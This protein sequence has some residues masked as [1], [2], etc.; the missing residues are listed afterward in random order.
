MYVKKKTETCKTCRT[1]AKLAGFARNLREICANLRNCFCKTYANLRKNYGPVC[2]GTVCSCLML[3]GAAPA[4]P[5]ERPHRRAR[6][7]VVAVLRRSSARRERT[8][9]RAPSSR[10]GASSRSARRTSAWAS[11][12]PRSRAAGALRFI[13]MLRQEQTVP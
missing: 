8:S 5:M 2:Y 10:S 3:A 13:R 11:T 7:V 9:R 6:H 4:G 1:C 12:R